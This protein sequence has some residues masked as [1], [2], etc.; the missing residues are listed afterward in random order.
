MSALLLAGR[1]LPGGNHATP[2][3]AVY[4]PHNGQRPAG[5]ASPA[6]RSWPKSASAPRP[7]HAPHRSSDSSRSAD[8]GLHSADNGQGAGANGACSPSSSS[9]RRL[10]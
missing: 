9:S 8:W 5:P 3:Q 1:Q 7:D 6:P 2:L 10:A 4:S